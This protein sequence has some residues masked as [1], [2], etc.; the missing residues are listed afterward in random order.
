LKKANNA[1]FII[2]ADVQ[3][4]KI[5]SELKI[6]LNFPI[7]ESGTSAAILKEIIMLTARHRS[8]G[9]N[10]VVSGFSL[11]FLITQVACSDNSPR[12]QVV[13]GPKAESEAAVPRDY[14][15]NY[16]GFAGFDRVSALKV[17]E[18]QDI[19]YRGQET[20]GKTAFEQ[21]HGL[22]FSDGQGEMVVIPGQ[23]PPVADPDYV[24][25][26]ELKLKMREL[27]AQLVVNLPQSLSSAI[28]VPTSFVAQDDFESSSS[29]GRFIA[30]Q[31]LYEFNQ[32]GLAT[33]EIRM[34]GRL[35]MREDGEF[36]LARQNKA[37]ALESGALYLAGTYYT[38]QST[39]FINARLIR[40]GG[41][42][43]RTGQ[44]IMPLNP[45]VK[46]ML[47][48]SGKKIIEQNIDILDFEQEARPSQTRTAFDQGLDIH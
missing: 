5:I 4:K 42:I 2:Q 34:T 18:H 20:P 10:A 15:G 11:L 33:K 17:T 24:D 39:I 31:M 8:L 30:D 7:R 29:L 28:A 44:I 38:E 25:A 21:E 19:L 3:T 1:T 26:R 45:L 14:T 32:R 43:L 46:R 22:V 9:F 16:P 41:Q 13:P 36:I 35:V 47:S 40:A 23:R 48:A 6:I 27:A 12:A 37:S